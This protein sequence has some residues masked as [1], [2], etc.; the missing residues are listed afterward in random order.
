MTSLMNISPNTR[1]TYMSLWTADAGLDDPMT[2]FL[3]QAAYLLSLSSPPEILTLHRFIPEASVDP[4]LARALCNAYGQLAARG[5]TILV[6]LHSTA[7][8]LDT[9]LIGFTCQ[10]LPAAHSTL[11]I[12]LLTRCTS[13]THSSA[14]SVGGT[15]LPSGCETT[16]TS[17]NGGFSTLISHL[18]LILEASFPIAATAFGSIDSS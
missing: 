1:A 7:L 17:N 5:V 18:W 6:I 3:D 11:S 16:L 14:T 8:T 9:A 13:S 10:S 2:W 12:P 15:E 4:D